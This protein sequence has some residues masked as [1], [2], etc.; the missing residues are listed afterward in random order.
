[1]ARERELATRMAKAP[2]SVKKSAETPRTPHR[3]ERLIRKEL[4][5]VEKLIARLDDQKKKATN[6]SVDWSNA[7][8]AVKGGHVQINGQACKPAREMKAGDLVV[9][10]AGEITRTLRFVAAPPSRVAAKLVAR[11]EQ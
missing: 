10:R 9:A 4:S 2:Q 5:T 7:A 11:H 1:M 6:Q 3:D 8:D